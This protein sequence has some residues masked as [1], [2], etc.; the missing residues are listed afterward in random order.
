MP[1]SV[2]LFLMEKRCTF[3]STKPNHRWTWRVAWRLKRPF[4]WSAR[5][6]RTTTANPPTWR[7][8]I[9]SLL[10]KKPVS[11]AICPTIRTASTSST[12]RSRPFPS[13]YVSARPLMI[14]TMT[15]FMQFSHFAAW[16]VLTRLSVS[17]RCLLSKRLW[18]D[19]LSQLI[20]MIE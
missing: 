14:P 11:I 17:T 20:M 7:T 19:I 1:S 5:C 3:F 13:P 16:T 9:A 10:L 15:C 6:V 8:S 2:P 4:P 18:L 12:Q